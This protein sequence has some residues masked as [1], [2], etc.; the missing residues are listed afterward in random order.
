MPSRAPEYAVSLFLP[1]TRGTSVAA[2]RCA[3]SCVPGPAAAGAACRPP[4][5][6]RGSPPAAWAGVR[7]EDFSRGSGCAWVVELG[8]KAASAAMPRRQFTH[9]AAHGCQPGAPVGASEEGSQDAQHACVSQESDQ[10]RVA[11]WQGSCTKWV[12][13]GSGPALSSGGGGRRCRQPA[14]TRVAQ[15]CPIARFSASEWPEKAPGHRELAT[16]AR[17][18]LRCLSR[19]RA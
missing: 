15:S 2:D 4:R 16:C 19:L 5:R 7:R 11:A 14:H 13:A 3:S 17:P 9:R 1:S 18:H 10:S 12:D 6:S 8:S